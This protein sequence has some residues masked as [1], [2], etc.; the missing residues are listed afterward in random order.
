MAP[1]ISWWLL[2]A[3][4]QSSCDWQNLRWQDLNSNLN[5][6]GKGSRVDN[7]VLQEHDGRVL[8]LAAATQLDK[9]RLDVAA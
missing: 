3:T 6:E 8:L 7:V 4:L 5:H 9:A 2:F 1:Q